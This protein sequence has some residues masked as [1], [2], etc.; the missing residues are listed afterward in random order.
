MRAE[1]RTDM[2]KLLVAFRNFANTPKKRSLRGT[3]AVNITR[4]TLTGMKWQI[5]TTHKK[6]KKKEGKC[7][8][9]SVFTDFN[10]TPLT[11]IREGT[12]TSTH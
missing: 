12:Y 11:R 1:G 2:K 10:T 5:H 9:L 3:T 6:K 7:K 4:I 8:F